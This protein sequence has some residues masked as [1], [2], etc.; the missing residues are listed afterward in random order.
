MLVE[1]RASLDFEFGW[2]RGLKR[3]ESDSVLFCNDCDSN[4][5]LSSFPLCS[6]A[7][8]TRLTCCARSAPSL[9]RSRRDMKLKIVLGV[10]GAII[11]IIIVVSIVVSVK[12]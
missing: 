12:K 5:Y 7:H 11:V 2:S 8:F 1:V 3:I 10:V 6:L 4:E 9:A